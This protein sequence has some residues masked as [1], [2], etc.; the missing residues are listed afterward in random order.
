MGRIV[1]PHGVRG[2]VSMKALTAYP[3]HLST[4]RQLYVGAGRQPFAVR[5]IRHRDETM[6]LVQFEG[7]DDRN[8]AESL[9]EEMV[10]VHID[11]AVPLEEDEYYLY[12]IE[13]IRVVTSDGE[14]L[15][16]V[17]DIIETGANDVYVI[18]APDGAE[19]LIPAIEDVIQSVDVAEGLMVVRLLDGLL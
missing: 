19:H 16:Q 11:N 15:G 8:A 3:E 4:Q 12:Q 5:R 1:R 2:E 14:A 18:T 10:Y 7:V 13:G 17:T 6:L 9:R